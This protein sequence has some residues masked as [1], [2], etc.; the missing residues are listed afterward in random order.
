VLACFAVGLLCAAGAA[1]LGFRFAIER[2]G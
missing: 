1:I 2:L